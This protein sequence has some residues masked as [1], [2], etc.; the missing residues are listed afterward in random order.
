MRSLTLRRIFADYHGVSVG[1]YSYGCFSPERIP[2]GTTIGRYCS[3]ATGVTI[4]SANHPMERRSLHPFFYNPRLG[5]VP[6]ETI[7]RGTI[8]IGH[9]VWLGRNAIITPRV[10]LIGDGAVVGAGAVVTR[11]VPAYAI[12]AGNPARLIRYRFDDRTR[13]EIERSRWWEKSIEELARDIDF[14]LQPAAAA[15]PGGPVNHSQ[16]TGVVT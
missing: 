4:F 7:D 12:V 3:F 14:F 5:I 15:S 9:D 16:S 11:D 8:T 1:M 6:R 10:S 13:Q 2:A